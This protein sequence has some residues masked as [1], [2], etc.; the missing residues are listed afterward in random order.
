[1]YSPCVGTPMAASNAFNNQL[2]YPNLQR[3]SQFEGPSS[4]HML[5]PVH[6]LPQ[7]ATYSPHP[8]YVQMPEYYTSQQFHGSGQESSQP[9]PRPQPLPVDIAMGQAMSATVAPSIQGNSGVQREKQG[10]RDTSDGRAFFCAEK[11]PSTGKPTREAMHATESA[12]TSAGRKSIPNQNESVAEQT[13]MTYTSNSPMLLSTNSSKSSPPYTSSQRK[14]LRVEEKCYLKEV[15][16]SIAEGRV[17][18]VQLEQDNRGNIVRYKAQ[19]LNALKLVALAIVP[20]ADIDLKNPSTVQ[21]IMEEVKRQFILEKPFPEGMV[22]RYLQRL[23][24]RNRAVYH[25]H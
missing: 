12:H 23:Y 15:K 8:G 6:N 4:N 13:P 2:S 7:G 10:G 25:R 11:V 20:D 9:R 1:M 21:R 17:P 16:K 3:E 24:K 19:F 18:Q 5:V 14:Q 22:A